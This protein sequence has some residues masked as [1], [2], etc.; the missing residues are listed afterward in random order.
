MRLLKE[1]RYSELDY[2]CLF[3]ML[4][5]MGISDKRSVE[6]LGRILIMHLLKL[7]FQ[8]EKKTQSWFASVAVSR[9]DL[10]IMLNSGSKTLFNYFTENLPN[11][12]KLA[13]S[14]ALAET[15]L[16]KSSIPETNPFTPDQILD[17]DFLAGQEPA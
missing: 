5:E 7:K 6:G 12:Y 2:D 13:R 4:L 9:R 17:D 15:N 3:Q 8:P 14:M 11:I 16:P 1:N 10:N